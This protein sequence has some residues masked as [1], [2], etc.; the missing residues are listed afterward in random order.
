MSAEMIRV[1]VA[2]RDEDCLAAL[3]EALRREDGYT[4]AQTSSTADALAALD[5]GDHQILILELGLPDGAGLG[6]VALVHAHAKGRPVI[7]LGEPS[8]EA[9]ALKAIRQGCADYLLK[10]ELYPTLVTRTVRHAVE[11][12]RA[13]RRR[14]QAEQALTDSEHRYRSLFEQSRDAI[15]MTDRDGEILELNQA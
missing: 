10:G 13:D 4:V 1:L 3:R 8:D 2:V 5:R 14:R 11:A 15:Y 12:Y 9:T 6:A 7:V